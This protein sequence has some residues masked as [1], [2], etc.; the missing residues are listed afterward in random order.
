MTSPPGLVMRQLI[1][2]RPA[3][4]SVTAPPH[5][6]RR[7]VHPLIQTAR[8]LQRLQTDRP[9]DVCHLRSDGPFLGNPCQPGAR[10]L[11]LAGLISHRHPYGLRARAGARA[12]RDAR[13][14]TPRSSSSALRQLPP[15]GHPVKT[16]S[17]S[18]PVSMCCGGFEICF[19]FCF[20]FPPSCFFPPPSNTDVGFSSIPQCLLFTLSVNMCQV[21]QP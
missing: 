13:A 15:Q 17:F 16:S 2:L 4:V 9:L 1:W 8:H 5:W 6:P 3:L 21:G 19:F 14:R 20:F 11:A 18:L 10:T 12:E 7:C